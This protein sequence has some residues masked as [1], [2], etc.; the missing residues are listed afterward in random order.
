MERNLPSRTPL[1]RPAEPPG[2]RKRLLAVP[3]N[4]NFRGLVASGKQEQIQWSDLTPEFALSKPGCLRLSQTAKR[5]QRFVRTNENSITTTITVF[6]AVRLFLQGN[7][8]HPASLCR[9]TGIREML[10]QANSKLTGNLI[11]Q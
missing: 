10:I 4:S 11:F 2:S 1:G 6:L 5:T 3:E 7:Q 9:A 8:L